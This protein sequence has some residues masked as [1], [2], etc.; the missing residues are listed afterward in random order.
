[1]V[2]LPCTMDYLR[3]YVDNLPTPLSDL[4]FM[5][6]VHIFSSDLHTKFHE[7][8]YLNLLPISQNRLA[9]PPLLMIL[10]LIEIL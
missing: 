6:F 7:H 8:R 4:E 5:K 3:L 1:M 9:N 2:Y 10:F